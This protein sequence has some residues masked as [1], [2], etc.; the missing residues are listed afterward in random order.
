ME[1]WTSI[2]GPPRPPASEVMGMTTSGGSP[3]SRTVQ[4]RAAARQRL[5]HQRELLRPLGW[6]VIAVVAATALTT[7]PTPGLRGTSGGVTLALAAYAAATAVAIS[8]RFVERP[9]A[10]QVAV[11]AV[12]GVAGVG[13]VALQP[14]GA[15]GLAVGAAVWMAM[16]RLRLEWGLALS[17]AVTAGQD[18]AALLGGSTAAAVLAATLFNALL[19]LVAY[20]VR[21]SR[22]AQD[23]TELLL[24]ELAE[25]R[26]EQIRAAAL[27][28]RSR[29]ASELHDVLAHCLS[30][31]AIQLQG[32]RVLAAREPAGAQVQE[33][34]QRASELVN[35]G[36]ANAR[37]AVGALRGEPLPGIADLQ[38]LVAGFRRDLLVPAEL[39]VGGQARPLAAET[40]LL[41]YRGAQEALTNVARY[42]PGAATTVMLRYES[43]RICLSVE[44]LR[45]NPG[46]AEGGLPG[47]PGLSGVGGGQGLVG[48]RERL[49]RAGGTLHA[50]PH[51][52][53][54]RVDMEVPA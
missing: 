39:S 36:L 6:A 15:T 5:R 52:D 45:A 1:S 34:V 14:R 19:G 24:A 43:A 25:A 7:P 50:G 21:A 46:P 41:L 26:D 38:T 40:G 28:E 47:S 9:T 23:R 35:D 4:A 53:G 27:A 8:D 3:S 16:T 22:A 48:L 29:I 37:A 54:W 20:V 17:V 44:N 12:M 49:E 42:A 10:V 2:P 30:G 33:A 13:L 51:L 31:A 32:A 11:I 18:V